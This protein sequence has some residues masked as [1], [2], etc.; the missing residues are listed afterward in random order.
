[1]VLR[2]ATGRVTLSEPDERVV[3]VVPPSV[4]SFEDWV[5]PHMPVLRALARR[6]VGPTDADDLVQDALTRAWRKRSTFDAQ[7]GTARVWRVALLLDQ[8][9]RRRS[10]TKIQHLVHRPEAVEPPVAERLDVEAAVRRLP[11]RQREVITL[12]Y[13]ADLSVDEIAT[14][15]AIAP[16]SVKSHLSDAR[17]TLRNTLGER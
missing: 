9:R 5:H 1:M 6:E 10:R 3:D 8:A 12:Y 11:R 15:L 7:R 13:L 16:G 2:D 17:A 14:V 4:D